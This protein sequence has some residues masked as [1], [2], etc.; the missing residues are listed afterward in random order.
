MSLSILLF[1]YYALHIK[2]W[3]CGCR[4]SSWGWMGWSSVNT[5]AVR[6]AVSVA[7]GSVARS[8]PWH[9][10]ILGAWGLH[11]LRQLIYLKIGNK[12]GKNVEP[13]WIQIKCFAFLSWLLLSTELQFQAH[14]L[15]RFVPGLGTSVG[16]SRSVSL[17]SF[18]WCQP[19]QRTSIRAKFVAKCDFKQKEIPW[20]VTATGCCV[21]S[22]RRSVRCILPD[23]SFLGTGWHPKKPA[24]ESALQE[25]FRRRRVVC[26]GGRWPPTRR[27]PGPAPAWRAQASV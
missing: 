18:L 20:E 2:S 11:F 21:T 6:E 15:T 19:S 17:S 25:G 10:T 22:A 4:D 3:M 26:A 13:F 8:M 16:D 12:T 9:Q 23:L 14:K 24:Q 1:T 5:I 27:G 7:K